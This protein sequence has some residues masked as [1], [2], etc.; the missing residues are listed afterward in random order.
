ML[1]N[2]KFKYAYIDE[3]GNFGY[4]F[5]K[6]GTSSHFIITAIVISPENI[7]KIEQVLIEIRDKYFRGGEIKSSSIGPDYIKRIN[8]LK[9]VSKLDFD[10]LSYVVD[11]KKIDLNKAKGFTFKE[12]FL[13]FV[14]RH[15]H[16]ELISHYESLKVISDEHGN[17][18][19]MDGFIKYFQSKELYL[20][21]TYDFEYGK[22]IENVFIQ[23]AD[24]ICG[25]I[26]YKYEDKENSDKYNVFINFLKKRTIRLEEW[27]IEYKNYMVDLNFLEQGDYDELIAKHCIDLSTKFLEMN[28]DSELHEEMDRINIVKFLL[29]KL[30]YEDQNKNYTSSI[31]LDH[32]NRSTN[33]KYSNHQF[34]TKLIAKIRDGGVILSSGNKGY[35]IPVSEKEIYSYTNHS[36]SII[37][38]MLERLRKCRKDIQALTGNELDILGKEEYKEI[39]DYLDYIK[40]DKL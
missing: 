29:Y 37:Y 34:Q 14:H 5:D 28:S 20:V 32:L 7:D 6:S 19:F 10:V 17:Q 16:E 2:K 4:D 22:S 23:L 33:R 9:E 15:L 8:I 36:V 11:K 25:T 30:R 35:K 38:P 31:I 3:S 12:A 21:S 39:K 27:P 18:D 13:K 24:L 26:A 40:R 1:I